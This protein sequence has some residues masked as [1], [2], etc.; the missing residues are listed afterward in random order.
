MAEKA[1]AVPFE[2]SEIIEVAVE[3]FRKR[4][5]SLSPLQ[6]AKEY[7]AFEISFN[8]TVRLVKLGNSGA[9][10]TLAWGAVKAGAGEKDAEVIEVPD[11]AL[12]QSGL[13]VNQVRLDHDLPLTVEGSDGKG[14]RVRRKQKVSDDGKRKGKAA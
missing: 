12:F 13:D 4:L 6:G 1:V 14:G 11:G 3:E 10:E 7:A 2:S 5:Q 8:H 9:R